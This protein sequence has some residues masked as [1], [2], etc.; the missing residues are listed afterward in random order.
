MCRF[1]IS[2]GNQHIS[3]DINQELLKRKLDQLL[4]SGGPDSQKLISNK[5]YIAYHARLAI[6]DLSP[7][8]N[9]PFITSEGNILVYNGEIFNW[10]ELAKEVP[11]EY[12]NCHLN[13][14]TKFL[15]I[16]LENNLIERFI[17]RFRGFF[18][19]VFLSLNKKIL[20]FSR[21]C[22]GVKPLY[23]SKRENEFLAFASTAEALTI[24]PNIS[25][26]LDP[27]AMELYMR[28]GFYPYSE[29]AFKNIKQ[30]EPG[31]LFKS[32]LNNDFSLKEITCNLEFNL[33][34][35]LSI[36]NDEILDFSEKDFIE[37]LT[38][39][40]RLRL[41]S[42]V[43]AA[44][45]LSGG[46]DSSLLAWIYSEKLDQKLPSF[47]LKFDDFDV[48]DESK[49]ALETSKI[50]NLEHHIVNFNI[51]SLSESLTRIFK[52]IDQP[53]ADTSILPTTIISEE[54]SKKYKIAISADGGD[55]GFAGYNKYL[56]N[57]S[58]MKKLSKLNYIP[59]K[60]YSLLSLLDAPHKLSKLNN[61]LSEKINLEYSIFFYQHQLWSNKSI[62]KF[63][64]GLQKLRS[65]KEEKINWEILNSL[66][67]IS[68]LQFLDMLF[69]MKDNILYK[70]DRASMSTGLELREPMLDQSVIKYGI[71]LNLNSKISNNLGKFCLR[72]LINSKLP[73]LSKL[74]KSGF[75]IPSKLLLNIELLKSMNEEGLS[76]NSSLWSI[77][78]KKYVKKMLNSSNINKT[79]EWQ[80]RSLITWCA[81]K[82][83]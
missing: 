7:T 8:S 70:I 71:R 63:M 49:I 40:C 21:D 61:I 4:S 1:W 81:L 24:H 12:I 47:T 13:S 23:I 52:N 27:S 28:Y 74:K 5:N 30:V 44:L 68:K 37:I 18:S 38:E 2:V 41:L 79:Q 55:E 59:N 57:I 48:F 46:I 83:I 15:S 78:D 72:N 39:S 43:P 25:R 66:N 73:H 75:G 60:I 3:E 50:L 11:K 64:P 33:S 35:H 31:K 56:L 76:S 19:F 34:S 53:F 62:Y 65:I 22:F 42:D 82:N 45:L 20:I 80:I 29:S 32:K 9:Q 69:Y 17:S 6:Q 51:K 58:Y 67:S 77:L 26:E 10:P 16:L 54:I 14:D 36:D